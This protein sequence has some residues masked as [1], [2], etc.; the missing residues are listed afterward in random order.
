MVIGQLVY[1]VLDDNQKSLFRQLTMSPEIWSYV[2]TNTGGTIYN[3]YTNKWIIALKG[4]AD[5]RYNK[6][7]S[8]NGFTVSNT[9]F[10][11]VDTEPKR[12]R[13]NTVASGA[14]ALIERLSKQSGTDMEAA[15]Q[16]LMKLLG[17]IPN[18]YEECLQMGSDWVH[19]RLCLTCGHVV[20]GVVVIHRLTSMQQN[21]SR[22][23]NIPS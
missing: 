11:I 16:A 9:G 19:L 12:V 15:R 7:E 2:N 20:T 22:L 5:I 6:D 23:P 4:I 10:A 3:V 21:I 14:Q 1:D 8:N 13:V 17:G 18:G